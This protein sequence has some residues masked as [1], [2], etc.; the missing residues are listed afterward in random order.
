MKFNNILDCPIEFVEHSIERAMEAFR[1]QKFVRE[2]DSDL[3]N[4]YFVGA[5]LCLDIRDHRSG[6]MDVITVNH[7][8]ETYGYFSGGLRRLLSINA[9]KNLELLMTEQKI[10]H[11]TKWI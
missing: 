8:D 6:D 10:N 1:K 9:L 2:G 4:V 11:E 5:S 3:S 7:S